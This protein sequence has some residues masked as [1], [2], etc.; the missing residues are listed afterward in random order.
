M[1][2]LVIIF[3]CSMLSCII[4]VSVLFVAVAVF[5]TLFEPTIVFSYSIDASAIAIDNVYLSLLPI[6]VASCTVKMLTFHVLTCRHFIY[7]TFL[8]ALFFIFLLFFYSLLLRYCLSTDW[9]YKF[10]YWMKNMFAIMVM[11]LRAFAQVSHPCI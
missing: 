8:P 1:Y 7:E 3:F 4:A 11:F 10:G 5:D 9:S 6:A 2:D